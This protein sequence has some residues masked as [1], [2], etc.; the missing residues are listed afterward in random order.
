MEKQEGER[1][2]VC[3]SSTGR[4][5][6]DTQEVVNVIKTCKSEMCRGFTRT[7]DF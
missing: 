6:G 4:E 3:L 2:C 5:V 7:E 1:E